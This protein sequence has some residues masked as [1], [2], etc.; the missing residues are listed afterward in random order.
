MPSYVKRKRLHRNPWQPSEFHRFIGGR[1][2]QLHELAL[3]LGIPAAMLRSI[4]DSAGF[5]APLGK[6]AGENVWAIAEVADYFD[7]I[8]W[9]ADAKI[10]REWS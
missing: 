10:L 3:V 8:G 7:S 2:I 6:R 4:A 5:P 9:P 1:E